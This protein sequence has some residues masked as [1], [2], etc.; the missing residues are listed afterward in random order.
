MSS[1]SVRPFRAASVVRQSL[2][3]AERSRCGGGVGSR[4][5]EVRWRPDVEVDGLF[6]WSCEVLSLRA[7]LGERATGLTVVEPSGLMDGRMSFFCFEAGRISSRSTG[8]P[9]ETRKRRLI[10]DLTQFCGCSGGGATSWDQRERE[11]SVLK[12]AE[13]LGIG[14]TGGREEASLDAGKRLSRWLCR[15]ARR[16]ETV[17]EG[18]SSTRGWRSG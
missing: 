7:W 3:T 6:V 14:S 16:S 17:W 1:A 9:R 4:R 18:L 5:R 2:R 10:R 13:G 12:M 15:D 11:R 8:T